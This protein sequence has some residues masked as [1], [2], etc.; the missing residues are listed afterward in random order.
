MGEAESS[1]VP[2]WLIV[3]GV[4]VAVILRVVIFAHPNLGMLDS[5]EAVTGLM[6]KEALR[7][8]FAVFYWGQAYGGTLEVLLIAP[9]FA[10]FGDRTILLRLVPVLLCIL[11]AVL[12]WRIGRRTIRS[13]AAEV[14]ALAFVLWPGFFVWMSTKERGFYWTGLAM[15]LTA[16]LLGLRLL[17][18][19]RVIETGALGLVAGIGWWTTPQVL[20]LLLPAGIWVVWRNRRLIRYAP[21]ALLG[22]VVGAAP[23]LAFNALH[24]WPSR[25]QPLQPEDNW[26]LA[27]FWGFFW[28]AFPRAFGITVPY[29]GDWFAPALTI[30]F[31]VALVGGFAY[32]F[33]KRPS[34]WELPLLAIPLSL[35]Q[36]TLMPPGWTAE[37]RY[38]FFLNPMVA[39]LAGALVVRLGGAIVWAASLAVLTAFTA[40]AL[41]PLSKSL[42]IETLAPDV[43]APADTSPLI[44]ALLNSDTDRVFTDYW[45]AYRITF[46]SNERIIATPVTGAR[47]NDSY[48]RKVEESSNPAY[49]FVEGSA[50][51]R[52]VSDRLSDLNIPFRRVVAGGYAIFRPAVKVLPSKVFM[53]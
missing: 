34:G 22:F 26:V 43:E 53:R 52:D 30:P 42:S 20:Y 28:R 27:H 47:R 14:A 23:W 25:W 15:G 8:K 50:W 38:L 46:E 33:I 7:G 1:L 48:E 17:E 9:L 35:V 41:I 49:V 11:C 24:D 29:S 44:S 18:R 32:S 5:D 21:L 39:L 45:I 4:A 36:F 31:A 2:K 19:A 51:D 12:L 16:I 13:P 3:G 37:P 6:A 40:L 10:I